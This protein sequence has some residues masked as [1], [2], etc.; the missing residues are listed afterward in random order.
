MR[1]GAAVTLSP[2]RGQGN[3]AATINLIFMREL[4]STFASRRLDPKGILSP[5]PHGGGLTNL[6]LYAKGGSEL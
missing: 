6:R 5:P 2:A 1:K 4:A 3:S